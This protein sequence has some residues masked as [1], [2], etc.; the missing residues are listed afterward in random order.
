MINKKK[1]EKEI[2]Y[3]YADQMYALCCR[4]IGNS[5]ISE[6]I[7]NNGFINVFKNLK[8]FKPQN[9]NSFKYWIRK[10]MTNECLMYLRKRKKIKILQIENMPE[11]NI[12]D[13]NIEF[14]ENN[15][16]DELIL[17]LPIGY[18]TIFNL[19]AIEGYSHKE[20]SEQLKIQESTSRSQLTMAR[21]QLK[22][23]LIQKGYVYE[24]Q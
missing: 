24:H 2:Y 14:V 8:K 4:Y 3:K 7:L 6:E 5:E 23:M 1:K 20:I 17:K 22:E 21:R 16:I 11:E 18:R 15:E 9:E 12:G 13:F 10:I 19:Y